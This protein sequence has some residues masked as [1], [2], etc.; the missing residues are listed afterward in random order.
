MKKVLT[1]LSFAVICHFIFAQANQNLWLDTPE[2]RFATED[3]V[4]QIVPEN[5]A[6]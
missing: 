6:P 4:R 3:D 1:T 2:S 5:T